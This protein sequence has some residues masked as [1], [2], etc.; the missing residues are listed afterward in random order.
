MQRPGQAVAAVHL[1][2]PAWSGSEVIN[3]L[4]E[5]GGE[6]AGIVPRRVADGAGDHVLGQRVEGGGDSVLRVGDLFPVGLKHLVGGAAEQDRVGLGEPAVDEAAK[7]V[8]HVGHQP[9]AEFEPAAGVLFPAA[10]TLH[11]A[12]KGHERVDGEFHD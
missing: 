10:G 4:E 2:F 11:D 9:A 6:D 1:Q 5:V 8:V 3:R 12:V 7:V